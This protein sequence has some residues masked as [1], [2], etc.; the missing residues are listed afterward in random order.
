MEL[1]TMFML[2]NVGVKPTVEGGVLYVPHERILSKVAAASDSVRLLDRPAR[3]P[4]LLAMQA[5]ITSPLLFEDMA[6]D[7]A[8]MKNVVDHQSLNTGG[9]LKKLLMTDPKQNSIMLNRVKTHPIVRI[10]VRR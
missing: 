8:A 4:I 3:T 6:L 7:P 1:P 5:I 10:S 2:E 9:T